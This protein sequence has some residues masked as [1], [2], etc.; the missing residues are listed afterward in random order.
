MM[1]KFKTSKMKI[2][3]VVFTSM[4]VLSFILMIASFIQIARYKQ[5]DAEYLENV[6][7]LRIL[8][9]QISQ[10]ALNAGRG[11]ALSF[12]KLGLILKK[13][14]EALEK[15]TKNTPKSYLLGTS[16]YKGKN[17]TGVIK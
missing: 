12:K 14:N 4:L 16:N 10:Q 3:L 11:E 7:E 15:L 1:I 5:Q 13:Y 9:Q 2:W 8:S 6:N 17:F